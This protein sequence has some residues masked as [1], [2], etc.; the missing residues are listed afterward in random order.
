MSKRTA[1]ELLIFSE[2]AIS[3]GGQCRNLQSPAAYEAKPI[4]S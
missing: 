4:V 1:D 2:K 3:F